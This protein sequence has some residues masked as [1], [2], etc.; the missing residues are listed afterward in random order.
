MKRACERENC[1]R[2]ESLAISFVVR[3]IFRLGVVFMQPLCNEFERF[4][5]SL[6]NDFGERFGESGSN[7]AREIK[8]GPMQQFL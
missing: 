2:N 7:G 8:T 3:V 6:Q 1:V 4:M 5:R